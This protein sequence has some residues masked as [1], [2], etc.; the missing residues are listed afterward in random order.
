[1]SDQGTIARVE[2]MI[3][4]DEAAAFR[5]NVG[6][7][8][9]VKA[10]QAAAMAVEARMR[11][12]DMIEPPQERGEWLDLYRKHVWTYAGIFAIASTV[13]KLERC[14]ARYDRKTR[15]REEIWEHEVLYLLDYPNPQM[16]GYD[17]TERGMIHLESCGNAYDEIVYK[18]KAVGVGNKV[19]KATRTPMELWPIR[20]DY[21]SP[22]PSKD[23]SGVEKWW[24]QV[25]KYARRKSFE[26]DEI[27][28]F[29]YADPMDDLF[30]MGSLQ[31]AIDDVRQDKA[32]A[33]WNLDFFDS[34]MTPQGVFTTD[35]ALQPWEA[36]DMADHIRQFM[37]G[38]GRKV[39]VLGKNLKWQMVAA[40]PKD[41][42]FLNGRKEN[43][44]AILAAIGVPPVK[45]GLLEHAKYDN[46]RLQAEAFHRDTIL[47]KLR[48]LEGAFDLFLLPR[49]PDLART[50][51]VDWR[52]EYDTE[53]LLAEDQDKVVDRAVK[54]LSH[55]LATINEALEEMGEE[56][57]EDEAVG[58]LRVI[59]SRLV[60][61]SQLTEGSGVLPM[62]S[63][64]SQEGELFSAVRKM[65]DHVAELVEERVR[66]ALEARGL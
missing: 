37:V 8:E 45:V 39:L 32:M 65:E 23:G 56:T 49:Y 64:E 61:L 29:S 40:N 44:E 55:G 60:P 28:P 63:L 54:R 36:K 47:P 21:L 15:E 48:K 6:D 16:T 50:P 62:N 43:R 14:V 12:L 10:S 2:E 41:V 57:V 25:R 5:K 52:L 11:P 46:Y 13:A 20:P 26:L 31:P 17:L 33:G 4:A 9:L 22:Q 34:N 1:M 58:N 7:V 42:E 35:K 3:Q 19:A 66:K 27:L 38:S 18:T 24:F 53:E 51:R 59:D 30:G